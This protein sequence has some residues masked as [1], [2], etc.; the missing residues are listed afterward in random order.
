M[1]RYIFSLGE[2]PPASPK[3][4]LCLGNFDGVHRGHQALVL[5]ARKRSEGEVGVLLFDQ[6]PSI[7]FPS[8]KSPTVLTSLEDKCIHFAA[9][10]VDVA[11]I[12]QV[13][14]AFFALSA[15]EFVRQVLLPIQPASLVVGTDYSYG[16]GAKGN[17]QSLQTAFRVTKGLINDEGLAEYFF[18]IHKLPRLKETL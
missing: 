16:A 14:S 12:V 2:I 7:F 6:N 8:K 13:S 3:L 10:G 5:E 15:E 18:G 9:L 17:V 11:Y 1:K 4:T